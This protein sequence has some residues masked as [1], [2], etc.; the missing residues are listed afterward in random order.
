MQKTIIYS[1]CLVSSMT[2]AG[3]MSNTSSPLLADGFYAGIGVG[4]QSLDFKATVSRI[5]PQIE[6]YGQSKVLGDVF[7]GYNHDLRPLFNVGL[8]A[9]YTFYDINTRLTAGNPSASSA[10]QANYNYGIKLMPAVNVRQSARLFVDVGV[11]GGDFKYNTSVFA[12]QAGSPSSYSKNLTGLLLGVG[13]DV[14]ITNH[15]SI[16][17]EYRNISYNDW[18]ISSSLTGGLV[19]NTKFHNN[20]NQ[21]IASLIYHFG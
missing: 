6:H 1:L 8:E 7:V 19:V 21:F 4:S 12:R 14:A 15:L 2:Y 9:F 10:Y 11:T 3:E 13:T 5:S 16:R 18:N 17:G 20:A